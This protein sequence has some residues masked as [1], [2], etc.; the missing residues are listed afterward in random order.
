MIVQVGETCFVYRG[1][2]VKTAQRDWSAAYPEYPVLVTEGRIPGGVP[3]MRYL[4][5]AD[6][7][8]TIGPVFAR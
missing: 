1:E 7:Y 5:T 2:S 3:S 6:G 4:R 8:E